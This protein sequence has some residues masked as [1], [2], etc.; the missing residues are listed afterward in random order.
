MGR[1]GDA[2]PLR[3]RE[4]RGLCRAHRRRSAREAP[5]VP[6]VTWIALHDL[7]GTAF[8]LMVVSKDFEACPS[9]AGDGS[10]GG[11][12]RRPLHCLRRLVA[13]LVLCGDRRV[14]GAGAAQ[15][16]ARPGYLDRGFAMLGSVTAGFAVAVA[17]IDPFRTMSQLAYA[18][19]GA[20]QLRARR[21]HPHSGAHRLEH[22]LS[23]SISLKYWRRSPKGVQPLKLGP[24]IRARGAR[25]R[26]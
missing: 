8:G 14:A 21:G 9:A 25:L 7:F 20:P 12:V 18:S 26:P 10:V 22:R 13:V 3:G 1:R 2:V 5:G 23:L 16:G 19:A 17:L 6:G 24:I 15:G 11:S 4:L